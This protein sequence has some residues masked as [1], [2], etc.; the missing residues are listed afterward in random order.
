MLYFQRPA[1][2]NFYLSVL[3][4]MMKIS[5]SQSEKL[6]C[7]CKN[8]FGVIKKVKCKAQIDFGLFE[9]DSPSIVHC[10][11]FTERFATDPKVSHNMFRLI[12]HLPTVFRWW[13]PDIFFL[14]V[15]E[16]D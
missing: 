2:V 5:Q 9:S 11:S 3:L 14:A 8:I 10:Q 7:Y 12:I 6:I 16:M 4:L 1:H 15:R 13:F